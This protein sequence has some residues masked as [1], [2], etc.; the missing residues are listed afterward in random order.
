MHLGLFKFDKVIFI[1]V[2]RPVLKGVWQ[3]FEI[4]PSIV[5]MLKTWIVCYLGYG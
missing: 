1:D 5:I 3:D 2:C 4:T